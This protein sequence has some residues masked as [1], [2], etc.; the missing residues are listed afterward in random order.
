MKKLKNQS[1]YNEAVE[2]AYHKI[3]RKAKQM[4]CT[5]EQDELRYTL[6]RSDNPTS[7]GYIAH[8]FVNPLLYL[9]LEAENDSSFFIHFGIEQVQNNELLSNITSR[10]IR[11]LYAFTTKQAATI[12]IEM[13]IRTDWLLNSCSDAYEYIEERNKYHMFKQL[14]YKASGVKRKQMRAVA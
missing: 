1:P 5:I 11:A 4:L 13:A 7:T 8:E 12:N 9:R 14:P 2:K 6:I 10:F 3:L